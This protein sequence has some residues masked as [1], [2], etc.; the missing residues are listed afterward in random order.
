MNHFN[1]YPAKQLVP[2][3]VDGAANHR[4]DVCG[5]LRCRPFRSRLQRRSWLIGRPLGQWSLTHSYLNPNLPSHRLALVM[6]LQTTRAYLSALKNGS[7]HSLFF[8]NEEWL[9]SSAALAT[10][11]DHSRLES[12]RQR[13]I[14][15]ALDGD[16]SPGFSLSPSLSHIQ[17]MDPPE[18][19]KFCP[20]SP[21]YRFSLLLT[22]HDA[23]F[24]HCYSY[25]L[26]S[27]SLTP[28]TTIY[29]VA[30][31]H[32]QRESKGGLLCYWKFPNHWLLFGSFL[33]STLYSRMG[34][35]AFVTC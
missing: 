2:P 32:G 5:R 33:C 34:G 24:K 29:F 19:P 13:S 18:G 17:T 16:W 30:L 4:S 6:L 10:T 21:L 11:V 7:V 23:N 1:Y 31:W 8:G 14:S 20:V 28:A 9:P 15:F 12:H 26:I 35:Y 27:L 25:L 22:L 3:S